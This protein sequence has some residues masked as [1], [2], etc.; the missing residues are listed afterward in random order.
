MDWVINNLQT[1]GACAAALL[2]VWALLGRMGKEVALH[3]KE[4]FRKEFA[5]KA[6]FERVETKL[7]QILIGRQYRGKRSGTTP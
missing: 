6:D 4:D 2:A 5:S 3:L 1:W 7:D